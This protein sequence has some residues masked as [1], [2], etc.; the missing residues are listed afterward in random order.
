MMANA[1]GPIMAIYLLAMRMDKKDFIGT[2][3]WFFF[4][5]NLSKTPFSGNLDLINADTLTT[6]L[7]LVPV[8]LAGG[9][10]GVPGGPPDSP[11]SLRRARRGAGRGHGG[12]PA[13]EGA[14]GV[15]PAEAPSRSR[16][17]DQ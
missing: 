10:V 15:T 3:A 13:G 2:T 12:L 5:L 7:V 4:I 16:A 11:A 17:E 1:A 9:G 8:I 6:N 14:L